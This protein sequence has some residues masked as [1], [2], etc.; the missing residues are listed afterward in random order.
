MLLQG[1]TVRNSRV[2]GCTDG[3]RFLDNVT[4]ED[5]YCADLRVLGDDDNSWHY[6]CSQSTGGNNVILRGNY[7]KGRDTSDILLKSD[8]KAINNVLVEKN[9]FDGDNDLGPSYLVYSV[10]G[11][12]G[13]P[14]NVR[15][16]N[17][18]FTR[19]YTYGV[20][21]FQAPYPVW[22]NNVWNDTS[23]V[24]LPLPANC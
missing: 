5:S 6:D 14:T 19:N 17:N 12:Y 16:L 22:T 8:L 15:F 2:M 20:C 21:S 24:I 7:F 1:V 13:V 4:I 9:I 3:Y 18:R 11:G 23:A 10:N